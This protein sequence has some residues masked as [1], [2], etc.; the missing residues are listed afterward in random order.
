MLTCVSE[1]RAFM[2]FGMPSAVRFVCASTSAAFRLNSS[3]FAVISMYADPTFVPCMIN[4]SGWPHVAADIET[5][6]LRVAG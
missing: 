5:S 4:S 2:P 3:V 6:Q 1:G